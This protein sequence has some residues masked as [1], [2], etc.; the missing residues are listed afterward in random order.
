MSRGAKTAVVILFIL[1]L[2]SLALNGFLLWQWW[3]FQQ[4]VQTGLRRFQ[5]LAHESLT[6]AIGE[7]ETFEQS[8][9]EFEITIQQDFPIELEIPIDE[10]IEVPIDTTIPIQQEIETTVL[11]DPLQSGFQI[12]TDVTVPID[13]EVPINL[14]IPVSI[15][16]T[17]PFSTT[18]PIDVQ[19]PL[20]INVA[21][22]ELAPYLEQLRLGLISL[23]QTIS[24]LE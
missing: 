5:S 18:I 1:V 19:V 17:I 12:P 9:I 22:T 3:L 2:L 23:D 14:N 16:R 4:R 15:D 13:L 20:S 11:I 21:E 7:L 8:S 24:N 10:T 6:Q